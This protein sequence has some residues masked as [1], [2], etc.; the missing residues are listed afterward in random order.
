MP[1]FEKSFIAPTRSIQWVNQKLQIKHMLWPKQMFIL[2][3]F[4]SKTNNAQ[5]ERTDATTG[6]RSQAAVYPFLLDYGYYELQCG[7]RFP[8]SFC[9][10][11]AVLQ[12]W[13]TCRPALLFSNINYIFF[14]FFTERIFQDNKSVKNSGWPDRYFSYNKTADVA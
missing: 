7:C 1:Y 8:I 13:S 4:I 6:F 2:K 9:S 12:T 10:T 14:R 3:M 5:G 11:L